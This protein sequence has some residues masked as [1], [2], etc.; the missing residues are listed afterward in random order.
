MNDMQV[1][2]LKDYK[3]TDYLINTTDLVFTINDDKSVTVINTMSL[4]KNNLTTTTNLILDGNTQLLE[5]V[6]DGNKLNANSYKE[7]ATGLLFTDLPQQF[8]LQITTQ[9]YPWANKSCMGLYAT[10]DTLLTQCEP[11]GFRLITY[12]LDRP[13]VLS[14]FTTKIIA[15]QSYTTLLSNG[16][17]I[18]EEKLPNGLVAVTWHDPFKKPSYLFAL[19]M[20]KLANISDT[21]IT[22]SG[23]EVKLEIYSQPDLIEQGYFAMNCLKKAMLWDEQTFQLEYDLNR[24]MIVA[25]SDFNM[26]AMENKGLNI[27]NTK[28]VMGNHLIATDDELAFIAGVVAHEYFHNW[29]GNRVT[30]RDW[31]QLSLKEGLTIFRD[32]EFSATYYNKHYERIAN[33]KYLKQAQFI[34]DA[35][36]LA[37]CVQPQQFINIDNFYT[38]TVY[39]KGGEVVRM[40]Q[41]ILGKQGFANGLKLYLNRHDGQAATCQDFYQAM[42]D[43]NKVSYPQFMLWYQQAGTPQVTYTENYDAITKEYKISFKQ[44]IPDTPNQTNKQ[45]MLIPVKIGFIDLS[46]NQLTNCYPQEKNYTA[47]NNEI[48]LLLNDTT[49]TFTFKDIIQKPIPSLLR[50]FSAPIHLKLQHDDTQLLHLVKYDTNQFNVFDSIQ[51]IF[52]RKIIVLYNKIQNKDFT[53][54]ADDTFWKACEDLLTKDRIDV[55]CKSIIFT[56]PTFAEMLTLIANINPA[57]LSMAITIFTQQIGEQLFAQWMEIYNICLNKTTKYNDADFG[58]RKLKNTALFY[59][60]NA[61]SNKLSTSSSLQL[62]ETI[63]LGQ[64]NRSD[65]MTDS[66]AVLAA[67]N[68]LNIDLRSELLQQFYNK[69]QKNEMVMDKWFALQAAS[70]LVTTDK[71][72]QLMVDKTFK[73]TNPNKI[74]ALLRTFSNNHVKFHHE[75]SYSFIADKISSIDQFNPYV[76][77][78]IAKGIGN[79]KFLDATHRKLA[80]ISIERIFANNKKMSNNLQEVLE[81]NLLGL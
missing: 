33:V 81:A 3:P 69:W 60:I 1:T 8:T 51:E 26:G 72:D 41:T 80:K 46:G 58:I 63:S 48:V 68:H 43:A 29:T 16:N 50:D 65:N 74:Y 66:I 7:V 55:V 31:F 14:V 19:V 5:V 10:T 64:Y 78:N 18:N 21:Y 2:Y 28:A 30:C 17:K 71:L 59:I 39:E 49:T 27:F 53:N 4:V 40:Y 42:M 6:L 25:T 67:I 52:R 47:H 32:Q 57:S 73:A 20:G 76:A 23:K 22:L 44:I 15:P 62:I 24:Y 54:I 11:E 45:P 75:N 34:E 56:I 77:A 36:P 37:H 12:Y 9:I 38:V 13:D 79:V 61:M 35:G 70:Y